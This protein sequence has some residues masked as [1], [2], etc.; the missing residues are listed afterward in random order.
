[1]RF[2]RTWRA[3]TDPTFT[4]V[5]DELISIPSD[6]ALLPQIKKELSQPTK[7]QTGAL[8]LIV[9]KKP[10]GVRSPNIGDAIMMAFWPATLNRPMKINPRVVSNMAR[11]R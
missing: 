8:K 7:A 11:A 9:D 10:E 1:M 2:E 3:V 4:W 6:L 5:A